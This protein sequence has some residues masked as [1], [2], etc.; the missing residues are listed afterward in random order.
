MRNMLDYTAT[1]SHAS[2]SFGN[3]RSSLFDHPVRRYKIQTIDSKA[4]KDAKFIETPRDFIPQ[5]HTD[6]THTHITTFKNLN[7]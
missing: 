7:L 1:S 2:P 4:H 6:H 5:T 3:E